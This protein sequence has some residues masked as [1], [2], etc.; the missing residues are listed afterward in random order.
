MHCKMNNP[1]RIAFEIEDAIQNDQDRTFISTSTDVND[2]ENFHIKSMLEKKTKLRSKIIT[3][4]NLM[5]L[6][7][8]F[9]CT[10]IICV[11]F[12]SF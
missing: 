1:F 4:N 12:Y 5:C 6:S 8:I 3:V 10:F 9:C 7:S 11:L 2:K